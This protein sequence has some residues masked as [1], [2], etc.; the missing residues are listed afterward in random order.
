MEQSK[1]EA[2][3]VRPKESVTYR[4]S[5]CGHCCRHIE[6]CVMVDSLDAY[7]LA[8]FL[9]AQH[10]GVSC[11]DDVLAQYCEPI[12]LTEEGYPI[13]TLK[14]IG[15]E[16]TCIFLQENRCSIYTARPR[17][18]RLYPFSV[19]PGARGKDFEYC[20]CFDDN[21]QYHFNTGRVSVKDWLYHN[22]PKE[23]KEFL[24][25]SYQVIP[26]IGKLMRSISEELR[27]EA[28]FKVL[29]YYYDYFDLDQPFLPQYEQNCRS[30]L[31]ELHRLAGRK[32]GV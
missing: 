23:E 4:C 10:N 7:R 20:L 28:V 11:M 1:T 3:L 32:S 13:F 26:G 15:G 27:R 6:G 8:N 25:R 2:V 30:L 16:A 21:R 29:F 19:G 18:C 12:P 14:T 24:K 9:R 31:N 22:F 17:T 5:Q